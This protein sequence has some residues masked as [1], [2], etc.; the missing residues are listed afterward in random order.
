MANN[1]EEM[2][3]RKKAALERELKRRTELMDQIEP[4][5]SGLTF[6]S[7]E[8]FLELQ[9]QAMQAEMEDE[10]RS[11]SPSRSSWSNS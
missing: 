8:E 6:V 7:P 11:N 3:D 9:F 4:D 1:P 5:D 10:E 2:S